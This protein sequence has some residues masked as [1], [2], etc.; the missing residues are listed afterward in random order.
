MFFVMLCPKTGGTERKGS[1]MKNYFIRKYCIG[2]LVTCILVFS[3]LV[4][5]G[6]QDSVIVL[7]QDKSR[8]E[9]TDESFIEGVEQEQEPEENVST[10]FVYVCGAVVSPQVVELPEGSR[11]RDALEA[12]GG[13]SEDAHKEYINLAEK[14]TDGKKLYFPT[15]EEAE[16]LEEEEQNTRMGLVNINTAGPEELMTLPGI[17]ES[18]AKD[19]LTYREA[20]GGFEKKEDIQK[21][22]GIK[23]NMYDKLRDKIIVH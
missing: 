13:F 21:V 16:E 19:I 8:E 10:I 1:M 18:R 11:A 6:V 5:C 17:G 9:D 22:P 3:V 12:A 23:E 20:H 15:V 2:I 4:S 7:P 14:V